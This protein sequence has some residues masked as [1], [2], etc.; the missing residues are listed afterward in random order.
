MP[1][2]FKR[3]VL[4]TDFEMEYHLN[5]QLNKTYFKYFKNKEE[6]KMIKKIPNEKIYEKLKDNAEKMYPNILIE[7]KRMD[8]FV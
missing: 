5:K 1:N 6:N 2:W 4:L 3:Q 8:E 7:Y